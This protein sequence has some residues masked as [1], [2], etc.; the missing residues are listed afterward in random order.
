MK[1]ATAILLQNMLARIKNLEKQVENVIVNSTSEFEHLTWQIKQLNFTINKINKTK[2][3]YISW[4]I[5]FIIPGLGRLWPIQ[6]PLGL[7]THSVTSR[8]CLF[9]T[10]KKIWSLITG[11]LYKVL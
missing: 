4:P 10:A 5:C 1:K 8:G 7:I 6:T 9:N 3:K 11:H 2:G